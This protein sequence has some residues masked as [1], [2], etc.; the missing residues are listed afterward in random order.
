MSSSP[1]LPLVA[2]A[3]LGAQLRHW[4]ARRGLSQL[5]LALEMG[6]SQRHLSFV[7]SG[8]SPPS[9]ALLLRIA[10]ALDV[11]LRDR[12]ALL[13]AAGF[14]PAYADDAWDAQEMRVVT[15]AL[16]RLLRQHEPFPALV[17]DRQWNVLQAN[18]AAPRLFGRFADLDAWP[19]PRNLLQLLLDPAAL[20]PAMHDW[21]ALAAALL[22]RL[23]REASG[24]ALDD[25]TARHAAAL[26]ALAREAGADD[27]DA[28]GARG[29][30]VVPVGFVDGAHVRRYFSMVATVGTP[31]AAAAQDLRV[32]CMFPADDETEA[33]HL[34]HAA[35]G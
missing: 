1:A 20:R 5:A 6:V 8:R 33:W 21:P 27:E 3:G 17:L 22:G 12:N 25:A 15:R 29:L 19:R 4:R 32:E 9:R 14:A 13:V 2:G 28:A 24:V 35:G 26:A 30:P 31:R 16:E 23:R 34:A 7:E 18:A 11:P 10:N